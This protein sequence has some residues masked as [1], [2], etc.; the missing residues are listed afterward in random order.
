MYINNPDNDKNYIHILHLARIPG[1]QFTN[2][3]GKATYELMIEVINN[4]KDK[5]GTNKFII[6]DG[7]RPDQE[8]PAPGSPGAEAELNMDNVSVS[9]DG[10][11]DDGD[12]G[13][14]DGDDGDGDGEVF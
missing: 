5:L 14:G 2:D 12:D 3:N 11:G 10:E 7:E 1:N 6:L 13:D 9:D 8:A 4:K